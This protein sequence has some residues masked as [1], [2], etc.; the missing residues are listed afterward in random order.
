MNLGLLDDIPDPQGESFNGLLNWVEKRIEAVRHTKFSPQILDT[1][2][3]IE[4]DETFSHPFGPEGSATWRKFFLATLL[5]D[6]TNYEKP[7]DRADWGRLKFIMTSAYRTTRVWGCRLADG[8]F[9]PVAYTSWY[10]VAKFVFEGALRNPAEINDRGIF[11]PLRFA[12]PADIRHGYVFNISIAKEFFNT[13]CSQKLG[14]AFKTDL[15]ALPHAGFLAI[16]VDPEDSKRLFQLG[17]FTPAGSLSIQGED[18]ALYV[19]KPLT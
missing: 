2:A 8:K 1:F 13:P 3:P 16:A 4:L 7:A 5:A 19:R 6:W 14:L 18:E 17:N 9:T 11:M 10:P 12:K 15:E